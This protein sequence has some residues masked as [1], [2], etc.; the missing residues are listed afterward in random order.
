MSKSCKIPKAGSYCYFEGPC[1]YKSKTLTASVADLN[2]QNICF[3]MHATYQPKKMIQGNQ[4]P[5]TIHGTITPQEQLQPDT[6]PKV[7]KFNVSGTRIKG[8]KTFYAQ[9]GTVEKYAVQERIRIDTE[10]RST[11]PDA[12]VDITVWLPPKALLD[13]RNS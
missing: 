11:D 1:E 2:G 5:F 10:A 3:D 6:W 12:I 8:E 4:I 7:I 13:N 9:R